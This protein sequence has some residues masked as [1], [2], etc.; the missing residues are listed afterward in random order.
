[1][2]SLSARAVFFGRT[3][4]IPASTASTCL[5]VPRPFT[6]WSGQPQELSRRERERISTS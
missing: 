2:R 1:M 4:W 5:Q 3:V 6:W